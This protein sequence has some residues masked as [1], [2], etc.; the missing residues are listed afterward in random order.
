MSK[1]EEIGIFIFVILLIVMLIFSL[2]FIK[3]TFFERHCSI[4]VVPVNI[5]SESGV[6]FYEIQNTYDCNRLETYCTT[7]YGGLAFGSCKNN[8]CDSKDNWHFEDCTIFSRN[9]SW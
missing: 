9:I 6:A 2:L 8:I 4:S 3:Q 7:R 1:K 5:S